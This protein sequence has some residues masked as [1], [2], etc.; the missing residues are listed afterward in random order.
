[1]SKKKRWY[2]EGFERFQDSE[3]VVECVPKGIEIRTTVHTQIAGA[4]KELR[5][6]FDKTYG[7]C[8]DC[9]GLV[10]KEKDCCLN[11]L[12]IDDVSENEVTF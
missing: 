8:M 1:M 7:W 9:D 3:E 12:D 6:S 4:L 10:C 5:E 11:R 2:I